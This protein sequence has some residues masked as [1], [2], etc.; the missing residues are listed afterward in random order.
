MI[1]VKVV[2]S[3]GAPFADAGEDQ[4]VRK[5]I[6]V[7]LDGIGTDSDGDRLRYN[8]STNSAAIIADAD[9]L[10]YLWKQISGELLHLKLINQHFHLQHLL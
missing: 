5:N 10:T 3:N 9:E 2:P 4:H 6:I 8:W 7:K 1:L